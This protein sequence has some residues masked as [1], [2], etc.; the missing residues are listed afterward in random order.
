MV[1]K[2]LDGFDAIKQKIA[3]LGGRHVIYGGNIQT[4]KRL[5]FLVRSED[6]VI[7]SRVLSQT[8]VEVLGPHGSAEVY[9]VWFLVF[10]QLAELMQEAGSQVEANVS[11]K[12]MSNIYF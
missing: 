2:S 10:M 9:R 8:I 12:E 6:Y 3:T 11:K 1:V 4:C 7:F 5:T